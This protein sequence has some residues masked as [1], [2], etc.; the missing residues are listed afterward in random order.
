MIAQPMAVLE[1]HSAVLS[2]QAHTPAP[3]HWI[4]FAFLVVFTILLVDTCVSAVQLQLVE[5]KL[6]V[7]N[8][9]GT[10]MWAY[11]IGCSTAMFLAAYMRISSVNQVVTTV[12]ME[13]GYMR[14]LEEEILGDE[15]AVEDGEVAVDNAAEREHRTRWCTSRLCMFE[16]AV[17]SIV[18]GIAALC[19][20]LFS[21]SYQGAAAAWMSETDLTVS[22]PDLLFRNN[23][24][25]P[26]I[27]LIQ[28]L[29]LP[30]LALFLAI[31]TC[32]G[33]HRQWLS[34]VHAGVNSLSVCCALFI[35]IPV[36]DSLGDFILHQQAFC[37]SV[38]VFTG[39]SCL[40][41]VGTLESGTWCLLLHALCLEVFVVLT[42]RR[43]R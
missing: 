3:N 5:T 7:Q 20:P 31:A 9:F 8:E 21:V 6:E 23:L 22:L 32:F 29:L 38:Q 36:L 14:V 40:T 2:G 17:L 42:L 41:M 4:R 11:V 30:A 1:R 39:E 16:S 43:S 13:D 34:A 24:K 10:G 12:E 33:L 18:F 26:P 25:L 19:L 37:A 27:V 15:E 28:V 35:I